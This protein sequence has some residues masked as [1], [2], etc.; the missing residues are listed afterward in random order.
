[1][2]R[3]GDSTFLSEAG[4]PVPDLLLQ[5]RARYP[6]RNAV[7]LEGRGLDFATLSDRG[8]SF[9]GHLRGRGLA[10][11]SRIALLAFNELETTE[12]RVGVQRAGMTLLP[13][14]HRLSAPELRA[15]LEDAE[16]ELLVV[17]PG[18][19][20][21]AAELGAEEVLHLGEPGGAEPF[22]AEQ[23]YDRAL[24]DA[25]PLPFEGFVPG[26]AIGLI[27][28]TSGTTGRAKGV[29]LDNA[30]LHATVLA[31]GHEMGAG[32]EDVYLCSNPLFHV[33]AAVSYG[34]TYLG[35]TVVMMRRFEPD[36]YLELL[37]AGDVTHGQM[38]P[39]MLHDVLERAPGFDGGRL[40]RLLYGAAPMPPSLARRVIEAWGCELVNGY[41]STEAMGISML[42]PAEH[43]LERAPGLLA[44][45]GRGS[46]GMR[47]KVVDDEDRE[48]AAGEVGEVVAR[49]ANLMSGY[50]RLPAESEEALRGGWMHTGDLG[51]RDADDYL[52]LLDRRGDKIV[53]GGENVYPS[54]IENVLVEHPAVADAAIVG[55]P[56]PR[57]GEAVCGV[58]VTVEGASPD[59]AEL[60]DFCRARLAGYKV[61]KLLRFADR[62]PRNAGGK[63]VRREVRREA[64]D[65]AA[66]LV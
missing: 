20:E 56:H 14:N 24:A 60:K 1:M 16:P 62:L 7:V 59:E 27:S 64:A 17:G 30:A 38:V 36:A 32:P 55:V 52:F 2:G 29:M 50:W 35:A 46:V 33:G 6:H 53:S 23:A 34:F 57:W 28:Y 5:G 51:Y 43:D 41:G 15:Q 25:E 54:E 63:L 40:R 10:P 37:A 21:R 61:P 31:M 45:V 13:L 42:G 26:A 3:G 19:R 44:S 22:A 4:A 58:V 66:E 18:L 12:M 49:G 39:T 9:A 8:A 48:V 47:F 11:G 65:W